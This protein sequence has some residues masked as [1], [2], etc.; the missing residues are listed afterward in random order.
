MTGIESSPIYA[1]SSVLYHFLEKNRSHL[2]L[3]TCTIENFVTRLTAYPGNST[4]AS[5]CQIPQSRN[6]TPTDLSSL[7]AFFLYWW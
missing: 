4:E 6:A 2:G 5:V 1:G 7:L 3:F